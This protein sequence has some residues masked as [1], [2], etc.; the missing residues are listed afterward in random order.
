MFAGSRL[1]V[2]QV[3]LISKFWST[4]I[5]QQLEAVLNM[6]PCIYMFHIQAF[7]GEAKSTF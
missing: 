3:H 7:A 1:M 4:I 5:E 6:Q 2:K